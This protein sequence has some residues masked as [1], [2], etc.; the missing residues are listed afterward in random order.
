M[1]QDKYTDEQRRLAVEFVREV[2]HDVPWLEKKGLVAVAIDRTIDAQDSVGVL[3][4]IFR[5]LQAVDAEPMCDSPTE[6]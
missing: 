4:I 3:V 2:V 5:R 6:K 1:S